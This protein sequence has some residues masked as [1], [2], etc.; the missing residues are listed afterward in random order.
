MNAYNAAGSIAWLKRLRLAAES[1]T[2]GPRVCD[3]GTPLLRESKGGEQRRRKVWDRL[4]LLVNSYELVGVKAGQS[5]FRTNFSSRYRLV[6]VALILLLPLQTSVF[7]HKLL[8][9]DKRK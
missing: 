7:T 3:E 8:A 5:V 9:G 4:C 1:P 2:E 6:I